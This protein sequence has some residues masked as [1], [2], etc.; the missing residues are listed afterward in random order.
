MARKKESQSSRS[1]PQETA[2][3]YLPERLTLESARE[4]AA[5][6][7]ACE[8]WKTATQT[9]FGEGSRRA[10]VMLVGE[11]PGHR[12]DLEGHPFV[13]PAGGILDRALEAAGIDRGKTYVT[14]VVKHFKWEPRG[15]VRLH[16]KPNSKEIAAC[17]PWLEAEIELVKP[18]VLVALGATAAQA[19]LGA[20]FRVSRE[21]G[22]FVPS[23]LA[24]YVTA[25]VHPSSILRQRTDEER[26]QAMASFI[27]DLRR[28]REVLE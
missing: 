25:T 4:A 28:V 27:D 18:R 8:L 1:A 23:S 21:H 5:S 17:R 6:C 26:E 12:E 10:R 3:R 14:N 22:R 20:E 24:P 7:R 15:K 9:V 11:Q 16:K 13:G 2:A 19:L